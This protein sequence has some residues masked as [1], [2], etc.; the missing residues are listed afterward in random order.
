MTSRDEIL[1]KIERTI[2][3]DM[4]NQSSEYVP[5]NPLETAYYLITNSET[6]RDLSEVE[7]EI[8]VSNL[9]YNEKIASYRLVEGYYALNLLEKEQVK[10]MIDYYNKY[11][12]KLTDEKKEEYVNKIKYHL[13]NKSKFDSANALR[14]T[15]FIS[16]LSRGKDGFERT[17]QVETVSNYKVESIEKDERKP[18]FLHQMVGGFKKK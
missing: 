4:R 10:K 14:R 18:G 2:Q 5:E 11:G 9:D 15:I 17:K 1:D 13:E 3:T 16:V 8:K 6:T 7:K 12:H